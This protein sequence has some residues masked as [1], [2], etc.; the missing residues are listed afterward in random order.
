MFSVVGVLVNF[1]VEMGVGNF[2]EV[3]L[4]PWK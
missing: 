2:G 1:L 3:S 4:V